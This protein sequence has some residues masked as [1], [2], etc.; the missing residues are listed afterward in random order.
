V[1]I[2]VLSDPLLGHSRRRDS[3][4]RPG[5]KIDDHIACIPLDYAGAYIKAIAVGLLVR[6]NLESSLHHSSIQLVYEHCF[7][8]TSIHR[9]TNNS[10]DQ[11]LDIQSFQ[12]QQNYIQAS[13]PKHTLHNVSLEPCPHR[14]L[15]QEPGHGHKLCLE[16]G[17]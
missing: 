3:T 5:R 17:R 8:A 2:S 1:V 7:Y 9:T 15:W 14:S 6:Y 13:L 11:T 4:V 12:K 16:H 10:I